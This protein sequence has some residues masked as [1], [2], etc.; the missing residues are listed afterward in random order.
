MQLQR[1]E[2]LFRIDELM[3]MT[4]WLLA[5]EHSEEAIV[6][7][8]RKCHTSDPLESVIASLGWTYKSGQALTAMRKLALAREV[9]IG[10]DVT[11]EEAFFVANS[12]CD[13]TVCIAG[14]DNDAFRK[15]GKP[16]KITRKKLS[17]TLCM[18]YIRDL[19]VSSGKSA[20]LE[21]E[22]T[23]Q[24]MREVQKLIRKDD[25][26]LSERIEKVSMSDNADNL[27]YFKMHEGHGKE[28]PKNNLTYTYQEI[29]KKLNDLKKPS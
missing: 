12:M 7:A 8:Y 23:T 14:A 25:K 21:P 11:P 16:Q 28:R 22:R 20:L 24:F 26:F 9:A 2:A 17:F 27:S 15:K 18:E 3:Q 4:N 6:A 19:F 1:D 5:T 10:D 29:R 13:A